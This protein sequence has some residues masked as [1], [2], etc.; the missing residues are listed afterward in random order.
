MLR[1]RGGAKGEGVR[2]WGWDREARGGWRNSTVTE[3]FA[4]HTVSHLSSSRTASTLLFL[5]HSDIYTHDWN[6]TKIS[7]TEHM[8]FSFFVQYATLEFF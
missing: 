7:F 1:L 6:V 4:S 8:D 2:G 3:V 5:F